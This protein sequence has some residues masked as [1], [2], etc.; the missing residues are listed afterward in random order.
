M[1][2]IIGATLF[3]FNVAE[4]QILNDVVWNSVHGEHSEDVA[5]DGLK[6]SGRLVVLSFWSVHCSPCLAALPKINSLAKKFD[7]DSVAFVWLN[8]HD[9]YSDR[10]DS[11]VEKQTS[12][13]FAFD[14]VKYTWKKFGEPPWGRVVVFSLD[15]SISWTG[16]VH[17]I[18][19]NLINEIR[20]KNGK[21]NR[22]RLFI[23]IDVETVVKPA[24]ARW[25]V[26][27]TDESLK[28]SLYNMLACDLLVKTHKFAYGSDTDLECVNVPATM[29]MYN[30]EIL[31]SSPKLLSASVRQALRQLVGLFNVNMLHETE[32]SG[33]KV[34]F[35][36]SEYQDISE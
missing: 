32:D 2:I 16:D 12:I 27:K 34:L 24:D 28:I 36:F 19:E 18:D 10:V 14:S 5:L 23:K 3:R 29:K 7:A 6:D 35:D 31:L 11:I 21:Y 20:S 26:V 33:K 22:P 30:V 4:S 17:E 25:A 13:Y 1:L 8:T 9:N 15:G